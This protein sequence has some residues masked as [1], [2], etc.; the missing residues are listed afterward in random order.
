M[1]EVIQTDYRDH[2]YYGGG[3]PLVHI[4][5]IKRD[6]FGNGIAVVVY[7]EMKIAATERIWAREL[8]LKTLQVLVLTPE[9]CGRPANGYFADKYIYRKGEFNNYASIDIWSG[10]GALQ[11]AGTSGLEDGSIWLNF[12]A[13][14]E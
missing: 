7:G 12:I 6:I 3:A 13:L 9:Y 1:V 2:M 5:H 4:H 10:A 8:E 11:P 14:G